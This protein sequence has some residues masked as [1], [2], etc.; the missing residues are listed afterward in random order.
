[1]KLLGVL[2]FCLT[3][4]VSAEAFTCDQVR[5]L[6]SEQRAYY[7]RVYSI[8]PA[9]QDRIRHECSGS[10]GRHSIGAHHSANEREARAGSERQSPRVAA[11]HERP[12]G[13]AR[14]GEA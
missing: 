5:A 9:Q 1:M 2:F 4:A 13:G 8:T 11:R 12:D 6:S 7:I 3:G 10:K 14:A